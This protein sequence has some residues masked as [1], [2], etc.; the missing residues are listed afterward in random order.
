[1]AEKDL[2]KNMEQPV[3]DNKKTN[4]KKAQEN[5]EIKSKL[6]DTKKSSKQK[7]VVEDAKKALTDNKEEKPKQKSKNKVNDMT[8]YQEQAL[9]EATKSKGNKKLLIIIL[10]LL[11]FI[12]VVGVVI[13]LIFLLRPEEEPPKAV[14]CNVE[15]LSYAVN[16]ESEDYIVSNS[17]GKFNFNEGTETTSH[18]TKDIEETINDVYDISLVYLVNNVTSNNYTYTFNFSNMVIENCNVVVKISNGQTFNV[19]N[20]SK[21]I[22]IT[23]AGDVTLEVRF[24]VKDITIPDI[25]NVTKC[26][27][28]IDLTLSLV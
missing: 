12:V 24:S 23:Q 5:K 1:M 26:E 6:T 7:E 15:V 21:V 20:E 13:A 4:S 16:L 14:V 17:I 10:L 28:G 9:Q 22:T 27:G 11:G 18:F 2:K 3:K 19:T 8:S 25:E